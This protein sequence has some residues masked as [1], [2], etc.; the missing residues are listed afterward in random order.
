[1]KTRREIRQSLPST[2]GEGLL[3]TLAESLKQKWFVRE[4]DTTEQIPV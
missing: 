4:K 3:S 1:M 2:E